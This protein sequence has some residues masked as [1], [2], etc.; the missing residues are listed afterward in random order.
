[1][2][3]WPPTAVRGASAAAPA[4]A[5][6]R[7]L[8]TRDTAAPVPPARPPGECIRTPDALQP[9]PNTDGDWYEEESEQSVSCAITF[10]VVPGPAASALPEGGHRDYTKRHTSFAKAGM[11]ASCCCGASLRCACATD[12]AGLRTCRADHRALHATPASAPPSGATSSTRLTSDASPCSMCQ[13]LCW[14]GLSARL[15]R[16]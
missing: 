6:A 9:L 1:M 13:R 11:A 4:A 12:G 5:A 16:P 7:R 15:Y 14:R 10:A 3:C 8:R 2:R